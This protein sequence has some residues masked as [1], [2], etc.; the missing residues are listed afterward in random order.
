MDTQGTFDHQSSVQDCTTVFAL[1]TLLSSVQIFNVSGQIQEDDLNNLRLFTEYAKLAGD[2]ENQ[3]QNPFQKL[4]F[5]VRDWS[6][7]DEIAYGFEGGQEYLDD[8]MKVSKTQKKELQN[9]R[10]N[11]QTSFESLDA[12]LMPHPG[13][14]ISKNN[15]QKVLGGRLNDFYL[16]KAWFKKRWKTIS[17][18]KWKS[19]CLRSFQMSSW[20]RRLSTQKPF[21]VDSF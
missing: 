19:L 21:H 1:S 18:N 16:R 14:T 3:S 5:L 17:W 2:Q 10:I 4:L 7:S 12:F 8:V 15:S 9:V 20:S 13:L 11:L 6:N